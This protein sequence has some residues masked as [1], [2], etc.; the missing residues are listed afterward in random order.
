[1]AEY[2]NVNIKTIRRW[3]QKLEKINFIEIEKIELGSGENYKTYNIYVLGRIVD[4]NR[5]YY[6]NILPTISG[7]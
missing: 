4:G 3:I 7:T 1:M 6:A 2:F 5:K